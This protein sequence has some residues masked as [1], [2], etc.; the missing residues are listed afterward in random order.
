MIR[1]KLL[2]DFGYAIQNHSKI[3]ISTRFLDKQK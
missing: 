1:A 3:M 2:S